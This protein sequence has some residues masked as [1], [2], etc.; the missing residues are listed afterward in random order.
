MPEPTMTA[1]T[2]MGVKNYPAPPDFPVSK[3]RLYWAEQA[4]L[5]VE[6]DT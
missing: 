1:A 4:S 5:A 6:D 3:T 2:L